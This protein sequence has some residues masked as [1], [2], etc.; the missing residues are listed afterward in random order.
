MSPNLCVKS[1]SLLSPDSSVIDGLMVTGGIAIT[2]R[3]IHSGLAYSGLMPKTSQS[4]SVTFSSLVLI[5]IGLMRFSFSRNVV[6]LSSVILYCFDL[7]YGHL[8]TVLRLAIILLILSLLA[9]R[10]SSFSTAFK[11]AMYLP[12]LFC[13]IRMRLH[14]L[15]V[16]FIRLSARS[17]YLTWIIGL[18][19]SI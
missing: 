17:T 16:H 2:V 11:V 3:T 14:S 12:I 6:G 7:Q 8:F 13:G 15:H 4:S 10:P 19:S 18:A 9:S 1:S 5:S